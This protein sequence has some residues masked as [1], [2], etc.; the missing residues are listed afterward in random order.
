MLRGGIKEGLERTRA[1]KT[2]VDV[3]PP[4]SIQ[5]NPFSLTPTRN[6]QFFRCHNN[7]KTSNIAL[8]TLSSRVASTKTSHHRQEPFPS[9]THKLFALPVLIPRLYNGY[10]VES[11]ALR[12][13]AARTIRF[14]FTIS[15]ML[16]C[17][18]VLDPK[19]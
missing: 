10:N 5:H 7:N 17:T 8:L 3:P 14:P 16:F 6:F 11:M 15:L 4:E 13:R 1:F 18:I 19:P 12:C 2:I 9:T